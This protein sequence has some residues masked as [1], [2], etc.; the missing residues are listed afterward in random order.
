MKKIIFSC[1]LIF[2]CL[3]A[4]SATLSKEPFG[5][6]TKELLVEAFAAAQK[7][8]NQRFEWTLNNGCTWLKQDLNFSV[9]ER[10]WTF[11]KIRVYVNKKD[12]LIMHIP[13]KDLLN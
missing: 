7:N 10:G 11:S 9:L 12:S 13:T 1:S 3:L 2:N 5:C 4:N 8:D 6:I